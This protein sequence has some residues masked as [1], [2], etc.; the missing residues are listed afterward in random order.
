MKLPSGGAIPPF[1]LFPTGLAFHCLCAAEQVI[2]FGGE[3]KKKAVMTLLRQLSKV[4]PGALTV[5]VEGGGGE[6]EVGELLRQ[7]EEQVGCE[8]PWNGEL[9]V[10]MIDVP[11]VDPGA[12]AL[13]AASWSI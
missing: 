8:D 11:L 4:P 12:D 3:L 6:T 5:R 10:R 1:Y 13:E 9:T 7:L 2:T